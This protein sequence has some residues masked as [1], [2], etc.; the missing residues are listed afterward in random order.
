MTRIELLPPADGQVVSR[1]EEACSKLGLRAHR[2]SLKQYDECTH[3]HLTLPG[4]K[5]TLEATWWPTNH[6]FWLEVRANRRAD[7]MP[8]ILEALQKEFS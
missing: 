7:W 1:F 3:W 6:S 8:P 5:G 2:G 4:Q